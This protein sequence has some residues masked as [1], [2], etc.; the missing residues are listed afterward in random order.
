MN[1]LILPLPRLHA[2]TLRDKVHACLFFGALLAG[3]AV[4]CAC[5][6]HAGNPQHAVLAATVLALLL[7]VLP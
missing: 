2:S 5:V 3:F 4:T 6:L 1:A 7:V